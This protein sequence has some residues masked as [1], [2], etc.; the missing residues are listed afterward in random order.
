MSIAGLKELPV[1][2]TKIIRTSSA[3]PILIAH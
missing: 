3:G 1:D 2:Y